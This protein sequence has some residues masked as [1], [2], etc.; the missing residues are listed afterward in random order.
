MLDGFVLAMA[1]CACLRDPVRGTHRP[2]LRY[3]SA[4]VGGRTSVLKR[5]RRRQVGRQSC[6]GRSISAGLDR[7]NWVLAKRQ[8]LRELGCGYLRALCKAGGEKTSLKALE[9]TLRLYI[10]IAKLLMVFTFGHIRQA[11]DDGALGHRYHSAK[12]CRALK[13][14]VQSNPVQSPIVREECAEHTNGVL[15]VSGL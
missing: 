15:Q 11:L 4:C 7:H 13:L 2:T 6:M 8:L 14:R 1:L 9:S 5:K 12:T 3:P 10:T